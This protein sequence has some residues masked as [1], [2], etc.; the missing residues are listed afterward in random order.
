MP[1]LIDKTKTP[2]QNLYALVNFSNPGANLSE[3]DR[4]VLSDMAAAAGPG[5][6]NTKITATGIPEQNVQGTKDLYYTRLAMRGSSAG[7]I[8]N[9]HVTS[10][11][12]RQQIQDAIMAGWGL[13]A[14]EVED[15]VMP[16]QFAASVDVTAKADSLLYVGTEALPLIWDDAPSGP[17]YGL[18]AEG[19]FDDDFKV[20]PAFPFDFK[21]FGFNLK[22]ESGMGI[23]ANSFLSL[24]SDS[25]YQSSTQAFPPHW[26]KPAILLGASDRS[27]QR[28]QAGLTAQNTYKVRYEG[29]ISYS[30]GVLNAP[31][32]VWELEFFLDGSF[33]LYTLA[34]VPAQANSYY[35]SGNWFLF[36]GSGA[37]S[38]AYNN[39]QDKNFIIPVADNKK[40]KFT[41]SDANGSLWSVAQVA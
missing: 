5:G 23:C 41:P 9:L 32:M 10:S 3:G 27:M 35:L 21:L 24:V 13:V 8:K 34:P 11:W 18:V 29:H 25:T 6:T 12:T 4:V 15:I 36:D 37:A 28:L 16:A 33:T 26:T 7:P 31:T 20:L 22:T 38:H 39:G 1:Q 19:S 14:G 17:A 30:G 2:M 40:L